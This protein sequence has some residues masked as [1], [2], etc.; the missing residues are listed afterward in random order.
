MSTLNQKLFKKKKIKIFSKILQKNPQRRV[1]FICTLIL[2]PKK[3]NSALRKVGKVILNDI[4]IVMV[5]FFGSGNLPQK[6]A[7]VLIQGNGYRDTPTVNHSVIRGVFEC[8]SLFHKN[9]R[10]SIYGAKKKLYS[11]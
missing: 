1:R 7:V 11:G 4:K 6:F 8:L 10:R 9:R 2:T 5:R 3:P